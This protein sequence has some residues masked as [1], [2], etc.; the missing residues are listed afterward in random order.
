[1]LSHSQIKPSRLDDLNAGR[2]R[3]RAV[4]EKGS[5]LIIALFVASIFGFI[6]SSYLRSTLT[7]L[8]IANSDFT[9]QN[10]VNITHTGAE[11]AL[12]ALNED[13]GTGWVDSSPWMIES[14][15]NLDMG[16]GNTATMYLYVLDQAPNPIRIYS[17][18]YLYLTNG[19]MVQKN[20]YAELRQRSIFPNG[21]T[22]HDDIVFYNA[23]KVKVDSYTS[24]P[25]VNL[26]IYDPFFNQNDHSSLVDAKI[27]ALELAKGEVEGYVSTWVE[28]HTIGVNGKIYGDSTPVGIDV[29]DSLV[30]DGFEPN[31]PDVPV[32]TGVTRVY[33]FPGG[34]DTLPGAE[35]KERLVTDDLFIDDLETL[36]ITEDMTIVVQD[37]VHIDGVL[38]TAEGVK[39]KLYIADDLV[40]HHALGKIENFSGDP[41][42]L[43]APENL[44][45]Y[46]TDIGT[47]SP[48]FYIGSGSGFYGALYAPRA[49]VNLQAGGEMFESIV[50][51][52]VDFLGN[53][54]YYFYENLKTVVGDNPTYTS[55]FSRNY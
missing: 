24:D 33:S 35:A 1:M 36:T 54:D 48:Y 37:D 12:R 21:I 51:K 32:L 44:I 34:S 9:D 30:A 31:F 23:G 8:N 26:G 52:N 13:D 2:T 15:Y 5:T 19:E 22:T 46:S 27:R 45:V 29:D 41:G 50:A 11:I 28:P 16:N 43:G 20:F 53:Y 4:K 10:L 3:N 18:V 25:A 7:E 14:L 17:I 38:K 40:V 39:L 49:D 47:K 55:D 6:T 42:N